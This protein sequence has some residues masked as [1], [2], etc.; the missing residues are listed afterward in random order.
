MLDLK[1]QENW[2]R[3]SPNRQDSNSN[4]NLIETLTWN[5]SAGNLL[6]TKETEETWKKKH[7]YGDLVIKIR[8]T[9]NN[10]TKSTRS[11]EFQ[12]KVEELSD[13]LRILTNTKNKED[14][15][16][17]NKKTTTNKYKSQSKKSWIKLILKE[18]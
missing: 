5:K 6:R 13:N 4:S 7:L 8:S 3:L 18:K 10:R 15:I 14:W 11:Q 12:D 2:H 16:K 9:I 1:A 17:E